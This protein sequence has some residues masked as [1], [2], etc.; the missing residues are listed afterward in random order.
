M[1]LEN[2]PKLMVPKV[3]PWVH[4]WKVLHTSKIACIPLS[5]HGKLQQ[6]FQGS[7]GN[8]RQSGK[9]FDNGLTF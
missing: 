8:V 6:Q 1:K 7:R 9:T 2:A 5:G 3:S 4:K